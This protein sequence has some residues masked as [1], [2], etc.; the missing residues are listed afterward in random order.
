MSMETG[1]ES[2]R[3]ALLVA[4][5]NSMVT[6]QLLQGARERLLEDG[7]APGNIS[8]LYVP[9]AWDLPQAARRIADSRRY[10]AI[11]AIGCVIR[12]ETAH[13]DYVAGHASD[14]L[15]QVALT[16]GIP[17][18]FGVLTTET[19]EQALLR[20]NVY[21]ADRGGEFARSALDMVSL[22]AS[23]PERPGGS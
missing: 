6:E 9:G 19:G 13:F 16:A 2:L 11:V 20:A 8:V 21:G 3:I 7:V 5:F 14:G 23:H 15:G 18:V 4:R 17:V 10:D 1:P 12:G 22:Y